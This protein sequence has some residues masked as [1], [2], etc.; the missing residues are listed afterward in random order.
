MKM[1]ATAGVFVS[2]TSTSL[3]IADSIA[4]MAGLLR[5]P[6][7]VE[8]LLAQA[9]KETGLSDFGAVEFIEPLR[10]LLASCSA[11]EANS[12]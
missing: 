6:F 1:A 10:R 2:V 3:R 9:R 8:N 4:D 5:R 12:A 7:H 11:P